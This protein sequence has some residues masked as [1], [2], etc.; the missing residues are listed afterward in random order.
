MNNKKSNISEFEQMKK[1]IISCVAGSALEWYD[2]AIYGCFAVTIGKLFFPSND[3]FQQII[4][5]FGAFAS[6]LIARPIGAV[7]FGYIGDIFGRKKALVISIY[8]MAIPTAAMGLL[9]TYEYIGIWA[10]VALTLIRILQGLALGGGFTGTIVFL[11]EHSPEDKKATYSCW[12]PFSLVGGFV[13]GS[14]VAMF[15]SFFCNE[16]QLEIWGW[17]IPFIISAF[18][19][20]VAEYVKNKLDDPKEFLDAQKEESALPQ[21]QG[22]LKN[23][24]KNHWKGLLM[25]VLTDVLTACGYFLL[26]VF[27]I[28]YLETILDFGKRNALIIQTVNMICFA[29]FLIICG[30][31]ADK[32][33][34]RRQ[35]LFATITMVILAYPIFIFISSGIIWKAMLGQL[36]IIFIFSVYY[37]SIPAAICSMLPTKVRLAGVSIAHNFA[38]AA[39]GAFA[40]TWAMQ[41]IKIT[42]NKTIPSVLFILSAGVTAIALYIWKEGKN[43]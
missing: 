12:A 27:F 32:F 39:F 1:V 37:A 17:R 23:L 10:G 11:Y 34:R 8:M 19:T 9:P 22:L 33:G 6:G 31:W 38:M 18:G 13:L 43:Y 5:S 41:L 28:T 14:I 16:Q 20:I 36:A 4:A 21:K 25:I 24:F 7:I 26:S 29:V 30:Q 3:A 35:M 15:M 2:F 42:E 40:S